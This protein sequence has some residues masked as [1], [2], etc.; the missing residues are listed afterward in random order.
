MRSVCSFV[1]LLPACATANAPAAPV[2]NPAAP[3]AVVTLVAPAAKATP[4]PSSIASAHVEASGC[5]F[6][7]VS[8]N[9]FAL[10]HDGVTT[11][12]TVYSPNSVTLVLGLNGAPSSLRFD[13]FG[14]TF[15]AQ[16]PTD[17]IPLHA[18]APLALAGVYDPSTNVELHWQTAPFFG[19]ETHQDDDEPQFVNKA[20]TTVRCE[21]VGVSTKTFAPRALPAGRSVTRYTSRTAPLSVAFAGPVVAQIPAERPVKVVATKGG[22]SQIVRTY[23]G[24]GEVWF[25]WVPSSSLRAKAPDDDGDMAGGLDG[26]IVGGLEQSGNMFQVAVHMCPSELPLY[27]RVVDAPKALRQV[28]SVRAGSRVPFN[29]P[30]NGD[31]RVLQADQRRN[32]DEPG[33]LDLVEGYELVVDAAAA[34]RC[35][36]VE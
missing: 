26:V 8:P 1:L 10:S 13:L 18:R 30:G 34:E 32:P 4:L 7:G 31:Y 35:V 6:A 24:D 33:T 5:K 25:G 2:A 16:T 29:T 23:E 28:G 15:D 20:M 11:F 12:A 27:V 9:R 36:P 21:D 14:L 3:T 22:F 19:V 17:G